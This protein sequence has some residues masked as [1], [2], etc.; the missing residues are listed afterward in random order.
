M[1]NLYTDLA[2]VQTPAAG[3]DTWSREPGI[4]SSGVILHREATY[5]LTAGTDEAADDLIYI[6]K[7]PAGCRVRP[8]LCKIVAEDPGTAFNIATIGVEAVDGT[9]TLNDVDQVSTAIDISAGGAFDLAYAAQVD[10]LTGVTATKDMWLIATLGT[11][12][13]PT[14]GQTVRFLIALAAGV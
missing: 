3:A 10:G 13:A 7:I 11:I 8:D 4:L 2:N 9:T 12:T 5:T 1:A 14:A 6:C